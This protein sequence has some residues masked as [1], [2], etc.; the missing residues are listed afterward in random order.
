MYSKLKIVDHF[1][2][3]L[4]DF[5]YHWLSMNVLEEKLEAVSV[6]DGKKKKKTRSKPGRHRMIKAR[7]EL[8][9]KWQAGM[10]SER[11]TPCVGGEFDYGD[12][13]G[14]SDRDQA[15]KKV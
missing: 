7:V 9:E 14:M 6:E 4:L 10:L 2:E 3:T 15:S 13:E 11:E 5:T 8:R 1:I 12:R